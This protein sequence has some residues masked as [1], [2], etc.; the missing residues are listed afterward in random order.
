[1]VSGQ[2]TNQG[3]VFKKVMEKKAP[4]KSSWHQLQDVHVHRTSTPISPFAKFL[5]SATG[6]RL[7]RGRAVPGVLQ[8]DH[9]GGSGCQDEQDPEE[10]LRH[11]FQLHAFVYGLKDFSDGQHQLLFL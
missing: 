2:K 4:T 7:I 11:F 1:M 6:Q 10:A 8:Q 5:F 9:L 3:T